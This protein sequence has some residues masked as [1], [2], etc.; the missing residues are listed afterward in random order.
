MASKAD[1]TFSRLM[2]V[3]KRYPML[4]QARER[5]IIDAW[6]ERAEPAALD[7]LVGSHLRLVVKIARGFAGYGLPMADLVSEGNVGLIRAV[8]KFDA[9]RDVRFASYAKWWVRSAIQQYV[10]RSWSLVR[11][12]T[13]AAQRR[14][15]FNL[16]RLKAKFEAVSEDDLGP[17][18]LAAI[19]TEL[20]VKEADVVRMNWRLGGGD[21]SLNAGRGTA[22]G[23]WLELLPDERPTHEADIIA[24]EDMQRQRSALGAALNELESRERAIFVERRLTS[25]P[26][27]LD[28][29]SC[30]YSIS[31]ERIRQI[32]ARALD[33]ISKSCQRRYAAI[34]RVGRVATHRYGGN[35]RRISSSGLGRQ[36]AIT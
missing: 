29:L 31:R 23:E 2:Q 13:T 12:G 9:A 35:L 8:N 27:T 11:I 34:N 22:E 1:S 5:E 28:E 16:R 30:R 25:E 36:L 26:A 3:G 21:S 33:K 6:Q 4:T 32:E 19:A 7:E 15:F 24:S 20:D 17:E 10:L 14:L 18:A